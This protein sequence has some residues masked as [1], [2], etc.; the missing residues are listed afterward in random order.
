MNFFEQVYQIVKQIPRGK[1][2]TYGQIAKML[3]TKD[4]RRVGHALHVNKDG[5]LVPCHRVVNKDGRLAPGFAFG[6]P[7]EQKRRLEQEGVKVKNNRVDLSQ[8]GVKTQNSNVK[9]Q[10]QMLNLKTI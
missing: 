2:M 3:G 8:Y 5:T 9:C 6:G 7:H 4:A 10:N 1:V